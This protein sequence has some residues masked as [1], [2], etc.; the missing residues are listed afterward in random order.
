MFTDRSAAN[1]TVAVNS[2]KATQKADGLTCM[3]H[4]MTLLRFSPAFLMHN[5][6]T[7]PYGFTRQPAGEL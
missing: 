6:K 7:L 4:F 3:V 2:H 5:G 1:I